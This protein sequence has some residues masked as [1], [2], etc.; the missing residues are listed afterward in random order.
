MTLSDRI[1]AREGP[2]ERPCRLSWCHR[3]AMRDGLLCRDHCSDDYMGRLPEWR[4]RL[5]AK[6]F[7]GSTAA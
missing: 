1:A 6:D 4:K 7:T 3:P 5:T 2:A